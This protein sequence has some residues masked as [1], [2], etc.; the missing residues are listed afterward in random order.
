MTHF[1]P[2]Y[3]QLSDLQLLVSA[4]CLLFNRIP[5]SLHRGAAV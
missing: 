2:L 4:R 5:P 3:T 1:L